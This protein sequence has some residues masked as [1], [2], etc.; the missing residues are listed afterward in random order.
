MVSK[1][2][3]MSLSRLIV[4]DK[5]YSFTFLS[6]ISILAIY[7]NLN[8]T[9]S[10]FIG[11]T[12]STI[13]FIVNAI[14]LGQALFENEKPFIRFLLGNLLLIVFLGLVGLTVMLLY[15]LDDLRT[16]IALCITTFFASILNKRM[17]SKNAA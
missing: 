6:Y 13:F 14:F 5:R 10:P 11:I 3:F 4:Q 12:T 9:Q 15:N 1:S 16:T 8:S 7:I 17:K 2:L